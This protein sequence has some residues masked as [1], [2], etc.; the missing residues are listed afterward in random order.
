MEGEYKAPDIGVAEKRYKL[1]LFWIKVRRPLAKIG[2]VLWAVADVVLILFAL[3]VMIDTFLISYEPERTL[4][5]GMA[6]NQ[7]N[8]H[9]V[10]LSTSPETIK[11]FDADVFALGDD[12]YDFFA[13]VEN[14][15]EDYWVEFDYYFTYSSGQQTEPQHAFV[16]PLNAKPLVDLAVSLDKAPSQVQ[17]VVDEVEWHF[18]DPHQI[19]DFAA[20]EAARLNFIVK[21]TDFIPSLDFDTVVARSSFTVENDTAYGYWEPVFYVLLY[22]GTS[23]AGVTKARID[24]FASDDTKTVE[25]NWFGNLP[26]VTEIEIIPEVDLFDPNVFMPVKG[27]IQEDLH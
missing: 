20:F 22:R 1:S 5:A 16:F 4:F 24:Q 6:V 11:L 14:K 21:D 13:Q 26:A 23:V 12:R 9:S 10:V 18:V 3:W 27:A 17:V 25:Q 15:N 2:L 8:R 7:N 19:P